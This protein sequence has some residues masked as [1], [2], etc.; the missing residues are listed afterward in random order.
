M[1]TP[2]SAL[3]IFLSDSSPK[4]PHCV[5]FSATHRGAP[6]PNTVLFLPK[7][8]L[9]VEVADATALAARRR[10]DHRIDEGGSARVHRRVDGAL[11]LVGR[12]GVH[13]DAAEPFHHLVVARAFDEGG[14][15]RIGSTARI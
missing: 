8:T 3:L 15:R 1:R 5:A 13:A 12:L 2:S 9:R 7:R 10:V 6:R 4:F 11:Q 14:R